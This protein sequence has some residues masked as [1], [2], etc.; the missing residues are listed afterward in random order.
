M[1]RALVTD[2]TYKNALGAIRCLGRHGAVVTAGA[3]RR[4][5]QGFLSAYTK[6]KLVYPP[7]ANEEGFLSAI[8]RTVEAEQI[9]VIL[10]IGGETTRALS[11]HKERVERYAAVPVADWT[12]MEIASNKRR[13]MDM[14]AHLGVPIPKTYRAIDEVAEFPVVVKEVHGSGG[15]HYVNSEDQL[16]ALPT[17]ASVIQEYVPGEGFGFFALFVGGEEQAIFMHRRIREYPVTGGAS[18]AAESFYDPVLRDLGLRLLRGLRWHGVAMVEFKRDRR[19]GEY[20]LMEI[21]PKFWGSLDLAIACG[22][23]FPWLA[24]EAAVGRDIE[25]VMTYPTGVRF[26]WVLDDFMRTLANPSSA[27][28][29]MRDFSPS[30]RDDLVWSDPKPLIFQTMISVAVTVRR[31][32]AG[33]LRRPH[34]EPGIRHVQGTRSAAAGS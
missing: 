23:E 17:D 33:Q 21:N 34:G 13:T 24:V 11:R 27:R 9:D 10:P 12:A 6:S 25:P 8:L 3:A 30:V 1:I 7:P 26:R 19:D 22:V 14:A 5:G 28:A 29:F 31:L 32:A 18:T 4:W 16:R 2:A 15:V 20:K